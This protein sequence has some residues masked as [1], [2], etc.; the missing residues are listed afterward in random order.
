MVHVIL[1]YPFNLLFFK[2]NVGMDGTLDEHY[3]LIVIT[4]IPQNT[5]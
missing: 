4:S 5:G 2:S 3:G 1:G